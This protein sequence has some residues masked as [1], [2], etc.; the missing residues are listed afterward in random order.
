[1]DKNFIHGEKSE[2]TLKE[3]LWQQSTEVLLLS[4]QQNNASDSNLVQIE[5]SHAKQ[6]M[7][8]KRQYANK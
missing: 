5:W 7:T 8:F 3:Q 4:S 2:T 1:M 6:T